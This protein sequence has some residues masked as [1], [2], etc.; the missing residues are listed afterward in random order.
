MKVN[1]YK[2]VTTDNIL[3]VVRT[4]LNCRVAR[5][6]LAIPHR[7]VLAAQWVL[8]T[9]EKVQDLVLDLTNIKH[10]FQASNLEASDLENIDLEDVYFD[11]TGLNAGDLEASD[12]EASDAEDI[13]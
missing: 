6:P 11:D 9:K 2:S 5:D 10:K 7:N 12:L 4:F 1:L 8:L 13:N 3:A